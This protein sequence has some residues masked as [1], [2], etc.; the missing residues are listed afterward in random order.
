MSGA[1]MAVVALTVTMSA[2][3]DYTSTRSYC[4]SNALS[5]HFGLEFCAARTSEEFE[6]F[7]LEVAVDLE[8]P[9]AMAL[10]LSQKGFWVSDDFESG[11]PKTEIVRSYW[12]AEATGR[13]MPF[14]PNWGPIRRWS[15]S[16]YQYAVTIRYVDGVPDRVIASHQTK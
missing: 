9:A 4:D 1:S 10:W 16:G 7:V 14:D 15:L 8:S 11:L 2:S 5:D 6:A 13:A 3:D 12:D